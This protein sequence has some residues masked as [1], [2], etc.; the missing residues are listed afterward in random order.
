MFYKILNVLH[1]I[2]SELGTWCRLEI[3]LSFRELIWPTLIGQF[4]VEMYNA[5][6]TL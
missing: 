1:I 2:K 6:V 3:N 5:T 4:S